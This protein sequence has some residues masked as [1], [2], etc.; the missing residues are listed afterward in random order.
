[1]RSYG[2]VTTPSGAAIVT[3]L[4]DAPTSSP[5]KLLWPSRASR[6]RT[7]ALP[8]EEAGVVLRLGQRAVLSRGGHLERVAVAVVGQVRGHALAQVERHALGMIDEQT[9]RGGC[10]DLGKQ[11]LDVRFARGEPALDLGLKLVV[12]GPHCG[13]SSVTHKKSGPAPTSGTAAEQVP[14]AQLHI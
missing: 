8:A 10:D 1:M 6:K 4:S 7:R 12:I 5:V 14:G 13:I 11:Q 9:Q 2:I 3:S